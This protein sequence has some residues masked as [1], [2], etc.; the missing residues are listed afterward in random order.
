MS[1]SIDD[2]QPRSPFEGDPINLRPTLQPDEEGDPR[3]SSCLLNVVI[4]GMVLLVAV[5]IVALAGAAGWTSGQREANTH[6][7]ATQ[8]AA[9]NDQLQRI[10]S[11]VDSGNTVLLDAR[12]RWLATQTPG[13]P[14]V[15]DYVMTATA[16][17]LKILPT[18]TPQA[19]ATAEVVATAEQATEDIPIPQA[20]S[21]G[22]DLAK[23]LSQ[24]ESAVASSQ[25]QDAIDLLDVIL[26]ADPTFDSAHVNQLMSQALNSYARE[27]Y[28]ANQPAE[29][30]LIVTRARDFGP[31]AD[32]LDY[33]NMAAELYL[34]AKSAVGTGSPL[35][36]N[37]LQKVLNLGPGRYYD[38]AQKLL[39]SMYVVRGDNYVATGD[40]CSAAGSYQSAMNVLSSGSANGKYAAAQNACVNAPPTTDPNLVIPNDG[41]V[42]P[43]GVVATPG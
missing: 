25:W 6:A 19:T 35:A 20:S 23:I 9:I 11:D 18:P 36:I 14:G 33:E 5:A 15:G 1:Y 3:G 13:V 42:A 26:G 38:D 28:N 32:G 16:L 37:D 22:Y 8:N 43:V 7:T 2:T 30:N 34:T 21:G 41:S 40:N 27:L 29:A 24:A 4:I 17:Y 10:P 39:Y 31:L 12:V